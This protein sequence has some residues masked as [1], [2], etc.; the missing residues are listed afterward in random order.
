MHIRNGRYIGVG[1]AARQSLQRLR[2]EA[3][4]ARAMPSGPIP[5][6]FSAGSW[7][8]E[9]MLRDRFAGARV[10]RPPMVL[11]PLA[12][13]VTGRMVDGLLLAGDAAG[14]IDPMTG[15]GLRFAVRGG[16]LAAAAALEALAQ[17]WHGLHARLAHERRR[18]F[19]AKWRFNRTL[20]AA[21]E[22]P[23]IVEAAAAGAKLVPG[24][25]RRMIAYAGDCGLALSE[26]RSHQPSTVY[27]SPH[28]H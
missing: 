21:V 2:R 27:A 13:D 3:R 12:A 18:E 14:F 6:R 16:E 23:V 10:V 11:G 4:A 1:A 26:S 22:R 20:R 25:V 15:D 9:P 24:V 7:T 5:R 19:A 8:R 28:A 17:G